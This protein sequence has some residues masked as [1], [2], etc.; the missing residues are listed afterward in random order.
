MAFFGWFNRR[1]NR[2]SKRAKQRN[3]FSKRPRKQSDHPNTNLQPIIDNSEPLDN[4]TPLNEQKITNV[5][6]L[7][8]P[9]TAITVFY[10][11]AEGN[12]LHDPDILVGKSGDSLNLRLPKFSDYI[13][14]DIDN[15][16]SQFSS[17][18]QK[19]T[20]CYTLR[21]AAPIKI[22]SVDLDSSAMLAP[23]VMVSGKLNQLY[24]ISAPKIAGY[25]VTNS[26]GKNMV[27]LIIKAMM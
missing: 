8:V 19:I 15:F 10:L 11:D 20:F 18:N 3:R 16:T 12:S 23:I 6:S 17:T 21:L 22:Y 5:T 4:A 2:L 13:L 25:K 1:M 24:D 27:T 9:T 14:T 26:T 7:D